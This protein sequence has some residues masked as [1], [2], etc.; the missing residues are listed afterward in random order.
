MK[1]RRP[2]P[3]GGI[4]EAGKNRASAPRSVTVG[5]PRASP[6]GAMA[7]SLKTLADIGAIRQAGT[8]RQ[9]ASQTTTAQDSR[10]NMR[11]HRWRPAKFARRRGDNRVFRQPIN[12]A[13]EQQPRLTRTCPVGFASAGRD[14]RAE[15][16]RPSALTRPAA[17]PARAFFPALLFWLGTGGRPPAK[18]R[19]HPHLPDRDDDL[20]PSSPGARAEA[21][22]RGTL[23][24]T[25]AEPA[26]LAARCWDSAEQART[27]CAILAG[28]RA[29]T[30]QARAPAI[31]PAHLP[32]SMAASNSST[33]SR[34]PKSGIIPAAPHDDAAT[35]R[36]E[37]GSKHRYRR[38]Q[39]PLTRRKM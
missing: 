16:G 11:Y 34:P 10:K 8:T 24:Q 38:T 9:W 20:P 30:P 15:Q 1:A 18:G 5:I 28:C 22:F 25:C 35:P 39:A 33:T 13:G 4:G 12:L 37:R 17:E 3:C 2:V 29:A 27:G 31:R 14:R 32:A 21:D 6:A 23:K 7:P 36:C 19:G 26:P